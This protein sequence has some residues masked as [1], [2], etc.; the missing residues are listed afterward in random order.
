[1]RELPLKKL[2]S[3]KVVT[4]VAIKRL[5]ESRQSKYVHRLAQINLKESSS[6]IS[7][8]SVR[9]SIV[10]NKLRPGAQ[11]T[12]KAKIR[13]NLRIFNKSPEPMANSKSTNYLIFK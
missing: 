2:Q 3:K 10:N 4:T 11:S 7:V 13:N 6:A 1:M 9:A 8:N 12:D 5:A